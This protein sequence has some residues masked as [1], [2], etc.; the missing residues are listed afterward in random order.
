MLGLK[1][2]G[3][4]GTLTLAEWRNRTSDMVQLV[5]SNW[6]PVTGGADGVSGIPV[7]AIGPFAFD[8]ERRQFYLLLVAVA[9]LTVGAARIRDSGF[10]RAFMAVRDN[11]LAERELGEIHH[12]QQHCAGPRGKLEACPGQ[13]GDAVC[14]RHGRPGQRCERM[15][16]PRDAAG[17]EPDGVV[18]RQRPALSPDCVS[19][20]PEL[21]ARITDVAVEQLVPEDHVDD[22]PV[23][24]GQRG[25][26]PMEQSNRVGTAYLDHRRVPNAIVRAGKN[27][28]TA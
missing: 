28:V 5:F 26:H 16:A 6:R 3:G 17:D 24:I 15:E 2:A 13:Q 19:R 22:E 14:G 7:L 1:G 9:L 8:T 21:G 4:V 18:E 20:G 27:P 11:E 25:G 10:G 23:G 12:E